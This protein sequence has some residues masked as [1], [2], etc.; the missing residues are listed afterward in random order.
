MEFHCFSKYSFAMTYFSYSDIHVIS[1]VRVG[2]ISSYLCIKLYQVSTQVR[3]IFAPL[4][5]FISSPE[6]KAYSGELI[7]TILAA[8]TNNQFNKQVNFWI[9]IKGVSNCQNDD[10]ESKLNMLDCQHMLFGNLKCLFWQ[11]GMQFCIKSHVPQ[12]C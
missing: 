7:H 4:F 3:V 2:N 6:L 10:V 1:K 5:C 11:S 8:V 12:C 9:A